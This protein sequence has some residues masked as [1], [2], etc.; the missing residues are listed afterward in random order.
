MLDVVRRITLSLLL[1][2]T[3]SIALLLDNYGQDAAFFYDVA[4]FIGGLWV[5]LLG[6]GLAALIFLYTVVRLAPEANETLKRDGV[7]KLDIKWYQL[8]VL[9]VVWGVMYMIGMTYILQAFIFLFILCRI[10]YWL[11]VKKYGVEV[12]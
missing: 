8:A 10:S 6:F 12:K 1:I 9:P 11:L 5:G 2:S 4:Y 7:A 3:G